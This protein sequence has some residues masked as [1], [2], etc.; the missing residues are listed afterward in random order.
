[1]IGPRFF[2][3]AA[4][5]VASVKLPETSQCAKLCPDC[6]SP[7]CKCDACW[8]GKDLATTPDQTCACFA[9]LD[10][11]K[12]GEEPTQKDGDKCPSCWPAD[13]HACD[14]FAAV[15]FCD[16][17]PAPTELEAES[18]GQPSF[19]LMGFL[20]GAGLLLAVSGTGRRRTVTPQPLL[21]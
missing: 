18:R 12:D 20:A 7:S 15:G 21:G 8:P 5:A 10:F 17:K 14:C 6:K 16:A 9:Q 3:L 19:W 1:M 4:V 13:N 11:C 2:A